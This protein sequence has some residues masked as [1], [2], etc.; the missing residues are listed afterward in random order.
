[1]N[2]VASGEAS[3]QLPLPQLLQHFRC[4]DSCCDKCCF[5]PDTFAGTSRIGQQLNAAAA[6][7]RQCCLGLESLP[8]A[9]CHLSPVRAPR[10]SLVCRIE[11]L[12]KC[13]TRNSNRAAQ[14]QVKWKMKPM[15]YLPLSLPFSLLLLSDR[16]LYILYNLL[17]AARFC[18]Q[19]L[20]LL[21]CTLGLH[22]YECI[23]E[24]THTHTVN[25]LVY[26]LE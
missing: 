23:H 1:M 16:K 4:C 11:N 21:R 18:C 24:C 5:I 19:L 17:H 12:L 26:P 9:A 22:I 7:S 15:F 2:S 14:A 13:E 25:Y 6:D 3:G 8:H 10:C 20:C